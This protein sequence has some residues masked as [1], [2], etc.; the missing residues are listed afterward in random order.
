MTTLLGTSGADTLT[1]TTGN[2]SINGLAGDDSIFPRDGLDTILGGEGNDLINS[3]LGT[4]GSY[5]YYEIRGSK[6]IDVGPG[7]DRV[8][9][10]EDADTILGGTGNDTLSG[11]NGA[12]SIVGGEGDD[13]LSGF[14]RSGPDT[15]EGGDGNDTLIGSLDGDRLL[16]GTGNDT[17]D[18]DEGNDYLDGGPGNDELYGDLGNDTLVSSSGYDELFGGAGNDTY[19]LQSATAYVNDSSGTDTA[20][21]SV[22]GVKVSDS[23]ETVQYTNG[24]QPLPYW[25]DALVAPQGNGSRYANL[26]ANNTY[27][28]AFPQSPPSYETDA[29]DR[30]GYQGFLNTQIL[31][32]KEVFALLE[33]FTALRF[34]ETSNANQASVLA[35]ANNLQ[36]STAGYAYLPN[37]TPGGS[38]VFIDL[39]NAGPAAFA[40]R[41]YSALTLVH[42]VGHALGLKHPF[43][44]PNSSGEVED[45]PYLP[46]TDD[47]TRWTVMS[48]TESPTEFFLRYSVLDVAALQ[49]LYGPP[50]NQR[51]AND[52]Y[53]LSESEPNF[54]WDGAGVDTVDASAASAAVTLSLRPGYWGY[55]G[56]KATNIT[57]PGQVTVNFGSTLEGLIGSAFNDRLMGNMANNTIEGGA[58]ADTL[59][60]A[61]GTDTAR[62]AA[63]SSQ[64]RVERDSVTGNTFV[65]DRLSGAE[66]LL[67]GIEQIVFSNATRDLATLEG[68][69]AADRF[70]GSAA[71]EV[72]RGGGGL[73]L[74]LVS[75]PKSTIRLQSQDSATW[76]LVDARGF[77]ADQFSDQGQ[78]SDRLESIE[79][80]QFSDV[81]VALD[82]A[83][84]GG[85][86]YRIYKA[87]FNR[88]PDTEGLGYWMGQMDKGMDLIE[89]SA[90]FIDSKEF[91]DLYG[92]AP[93]NA[94]FLTK[95]YTN[96]LGRTPDKGG[97]DWWLNE[98]NT[99]PEKTKAKV[100]AD[101]SESNENQSGTA[102]L[103]ATGIVYEPWVG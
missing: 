97:F 3:F 63:P 68:S 7:N 71:D 34:V 36:P 81:A 82:I 24:A 40:D 30:S 70:R 45:P 2:D 31:R 92:A 94:D 6:L 59:V 44:S 9:G 61:A 41:S 102:P 98:M 39:P 49:Y 83:G 57:A 38:D 46:A 58:G 54:L 5:Q 96:V 50:T 73:D 56:S 21:I 95:V 14:Q 69:F 84:V 67:I 12:D 60:G 99:N 103:V 17:L 100:L 22:D 91:R 66:D 23:I 52:T 75:A 25:I 27:F 43:S 53:I 85:K 55:V 77:A 37:A 74:L 76:L 80:V 11:G 8:Y 93:S 101:F 42:E 51:T 19:L 26:L 48:Y 47:M 33:S 13:R 78:G 79:R 64:F 89:V 18:G 62:Y 88:T 90:R 28:Y 10:G 1:G 4:S 35:F 72:F 86:A 20:I 87:A 65:T 29:D 15:I 32:V 16:G